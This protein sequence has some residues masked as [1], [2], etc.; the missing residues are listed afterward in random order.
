MQRAVGSDEKWPV[1]IHSS[2]QNTDIFTLLTTTHKGRGIN[3]F[4]FIVVL[5]FFRVFR[6]FC[7]PVEHSYEIVL[8]L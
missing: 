8:I 3:I 1:I 7:L 5:F 2:L 4:Q 6:L